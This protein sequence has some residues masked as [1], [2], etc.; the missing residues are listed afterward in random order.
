MTALLARTFLGERLTP[1]AV[2]GVG[3]AI[4]GVVLIGI[5]STMG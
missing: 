4:G 5:G 3:L 1:T 2:A